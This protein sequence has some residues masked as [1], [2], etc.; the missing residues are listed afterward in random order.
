MSEPGVDPNSA[1][2]RQMAEFPPTAA[3][4][5]T[6][7]DRATAAG[8]HASADGH[9]DGDLLAAE[10]TDA[11]TEPDL[12]VTVTRLAEQIEDLTR[13]IA[14]QANTIERLADQAAARAKQD[15]A[16]A[17]LPLVIELFALHADAAACAGTAESPR[18][19][20]AFTALTTR[21]ERLLTGRGAT[22]VQPPP[23]TPFDAR[24]MEATDT[25]PTPDPTA[26]RTIASVLQPGLLVADRSLRPALVVVHRHTPAS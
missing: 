13:V 15:R 25:L 23:N 3:D 26:D 18:E 9:G 2:T 22:L 6:A 1:H 10:R 16:G 11:A 14:R 4:R 7:T 24:T 20:D 21:I 12:A 19:L 8:G 5:A 17:D